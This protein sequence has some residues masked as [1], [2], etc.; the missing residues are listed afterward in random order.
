MSGG[1]IALGVLC[2]NFSHKVITGEREVAYQKIGIMRT[3]AVSG[4]SLTQTPLFIL[5]PFK[6]FKSIRVVRDI[7]V[8]HSAGYASS[9]KP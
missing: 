2:V 4:P 7:I 8:P 6:V 3:A 1:I 5:Q 9:L